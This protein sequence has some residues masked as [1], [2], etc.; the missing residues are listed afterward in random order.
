MNVPVAMGGKTA[1]VMFLRGIV[2]TAMSSPLLHPTFAHA[3][4]LSFLLKTMFALPVGG[5]RKGRSLAESKGKDHH[6]GY[7]GT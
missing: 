2:D 3:L 6:F 4:L 5:K 7:R 1:F